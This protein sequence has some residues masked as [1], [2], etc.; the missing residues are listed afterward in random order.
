VIESAA[1]ISHSQLPE[2]LTVQQQQAVT[3]EILLRLP[4]Q[5][6]Q[7]GA[8]VNA[9]PLFQAALQGAQCQEIAFDNGSI[10][11]ALQLPDPMKLQSM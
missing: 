11:V 2:G 10:H 9:D 4:D 7:Q 3:E 8:Q 1:D 6:A 5:L